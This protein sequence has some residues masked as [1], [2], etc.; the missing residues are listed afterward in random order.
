VDGSGPPAVCP[1]C[2]TT[3]QVRTVQQLFELLNGLQAEAEQQAEQARQAAPPSGPTT[4]VGSD[5]QNPAMQDPSQQVANFV[6]E[7][8]GHLIG[9]AIGK[10]VHRTDEDRVRPALD[11]Q[12]TSSRQEQDA[13][14]ERHPDLR[15]CL[16]DQVIFVAGGTRVVPLADVMPITLAHADALVAQLRAP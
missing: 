1:S 3:D 14:V 4:P 12:A 11:E 5:L 16:R 8:A 2:G 7:T 9:K 6:L 13:I 15:G 10:R